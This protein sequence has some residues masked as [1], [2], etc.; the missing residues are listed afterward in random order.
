MRRLPNLCEGFIANDGDFVA[1][2]IDFG[3]HA[4]WLNLPG[5]IGLR[6]S[7]VW[8]L[9]YPIKGMSTV[10]SIFCTCYA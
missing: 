6:K 5:K 8:N 10:S 2:N 3:L 9:R 1:K 7:L 4:R